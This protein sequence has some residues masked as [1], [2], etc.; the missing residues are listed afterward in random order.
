[1][2]ARIARMEAQ[3][4]ERLGEYVWGTDDETLGFVIARGLTQRGWRLA[5]AESLSG[6]DIARALA[7]SPGSDS[8]YVRG[9]VR[10][11]AGAEELTQLL[12]DLRPAPEV[13]LVI[14]HGEQSAELRIWTP[15]RPRTSTIRFK[16]PV[17]GRRR[18][19]LGALDLLR[20][21]L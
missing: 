5:S 7:E 11:N 3:V 9:F 20:R 16:S 13:R 18:A 17:E 1:M 12:D 6:G 14:P 4:R 2:N 21:S 15:D 10:P 19:L 8:W